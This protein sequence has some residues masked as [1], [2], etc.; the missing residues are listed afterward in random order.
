MDLPP[1]SGWAPPYWDLPIT[2]A[3]V[4]AHWTQLVGA[5]SPWREMHRDDLNGY[6]TSIVTQAILI[7]CEIDEEM[8]RQRLALFGRR[9]GAF[10][11][12]QRCAYTAVRIEF[13]LLP[14]AFERAL[15]AAGVPSGLAN[16]VVSWLTPDFR[17]A[18]FAALASYETATAREQP[19]Q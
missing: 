6:L 11:R 17:R 4:M 3:D 18:R 7:E 8:H 19:H 9:H 1:P 13:S 16:D 5:V 2:A 15:V 14:T 10:R 12:Q